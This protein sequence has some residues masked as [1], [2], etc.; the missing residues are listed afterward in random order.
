MNNYLQH[1]TILG[2]DDLVPYPAGDSTE[3]LVDVMAYDTSIRA[4]YLKKDMLALTGSTIYVRDMLAQKLAAANRELASR[5]YT[6]KVVYGYR[7]PQV[8]K[9][10]FEDRRQAIHTE[11]PTLTGDA[12]DRYTHI[13]IAV[14]DIAGHPAGAAVD[15][16]IVDAE[17][18]DLDMGTTIAD[19]TDPQK[20]ITFADNLTAQQRQNRALLHDLM[21]AQG[22]AP[23]Y[24]EWWHFSYGDREWAA[25][26]DKAALYG[27]IDF[28]TEVK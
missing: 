17:G 22:F 12:L 2:Y 23:F 18:R 19:F 20:I 16:T 28:T 14:P 10:Y 3:H 26:Y 7:H 5:G 15:I 13:F 21:V 25:F 8:Q 4:S 27:P 1:H 6:L 24:G 9:K 11:D